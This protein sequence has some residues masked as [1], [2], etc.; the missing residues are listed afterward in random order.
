MTGFQRIEKQLNDCRVRYTDTCISFNVSGII[1]DRSGQTILCQIIREDNITLALTIKKVA[2]DRWYAVKV[3][4]Y[5][6]AKSQMFINSEIYTPN[7][8]SAVC[9][10]IH[11]TIVAF[12]L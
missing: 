5:N 3:E 8:A 12:T 11:S 10:I 9:D 4:Y 2:T 1:S 6:F 7:S